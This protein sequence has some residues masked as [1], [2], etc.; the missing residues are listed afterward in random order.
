MRSITPMLRDVVQQHA[1]WS[2]RV[3]ISGNATGR[4]VTATESTKN[5]VA[6]LYVM[7]AAVTLDVTFD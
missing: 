6:D 7:I 4:D 3:E 2:A 1:P 5:R